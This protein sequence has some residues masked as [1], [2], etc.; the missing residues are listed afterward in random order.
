MADPAGRAH[1]GIRGRLTGHTAYPGPVSVGNTNTLPTG[2]HLEEQ[3]ANQ[4]LPVTPG[5][6]PGLHEL[7]QRIAHPAF[8]CQ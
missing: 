6:D 2:M 7:M 4:T 5:L 8:W 3:V 1:G